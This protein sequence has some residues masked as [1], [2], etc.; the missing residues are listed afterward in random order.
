MVSCL[1]LEVYFSG[2]DPVCRAGFGRDC[3]GF[4]EIAVASIRVLDYHS[5]LDNRGLVAVYLVYFT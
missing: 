1:R 2:R 4:G 3:G 5:Y